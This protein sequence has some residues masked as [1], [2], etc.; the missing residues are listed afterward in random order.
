MVFLLRPVLVAKTLS[1]RGIIR[2]MK[3]ELHLHT[4]R[5]S[6]CSIGPPDTLMRMLAQA[7]YHA[8]FITEHDQVWSDEELDE[9]QAFF[10]KIRIFP[11]MELSI[12]HGTRH[13]L[14]LGTNDPAYLEISDTAAI[15]TRARSLGHLTVLAHPFRWEARDNSIWNGPLPDALEYRTNNHDEPQ[16]EMSHRVAGNLKLPLVNAG[17]VHCMDMINQFWIETERPLKQAD[18][19]RKIILAGEYKNCP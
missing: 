9:L 17:D 12:D 7:G 10:P 3:V 4:T 11:G 14:V 15:I 8:A 13:L 5:Y 2:R 16:A 6:A 1:L 19:I 18:D